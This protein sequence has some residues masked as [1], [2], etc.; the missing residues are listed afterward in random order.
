MSWL[1]TLMRTMSIIGTWMDYVEKSWLNTGTFSA[2][3][4]EVLFPR[5]G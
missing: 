2:A 1:N 5:H 4:K 3:V